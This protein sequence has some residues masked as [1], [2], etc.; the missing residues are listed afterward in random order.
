[1]RYFATIKSMKIGF[2]LSQSAF[3]GGVSSYTKNLA[4]G[5]SR[6]EDLEMIYFYSSLR[7]NYAG[8]LKNVK[9][10]KIPP[11]I[12]EP[13]FNRLRLLPIEIFIGKVDVFH[14][15]DWTQPPTKAFKVT[16]YHDVVP[17][18]YP[19]WSTKK[20][21]DVHKRRL[22]IVEKEIDLVI[23][24]SQ[25]TKKDLLEVSSI[26]ENKIKV[27]YEGVGSQFKQ[28]SEVKKKEFKRRLRLPDEFILAIGGI[29]ERRNLERIKKASKDQ[30]LVITGETIP[31]LSDDEM[32]L[33]YSSA[34]ILLYSSLYEGFGLPILEAF[35]CG[36]PVVTSNRSAML[37]IAGNAAILVNPE[38]IYNIKD[39]ID[40]AFDEKENLIKKGLARVKNFSLE[41]SIEETVKVYRSIL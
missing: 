40:K 35:S 26:P 2:D 27:I 18:K 31:S 25:S 8:P 39:G 34:S 13:L 33:L 11:N 37:E 14:S 17:L 30:N 29:G 6:R 7:R 19:E 41:K 5:L 1:M 23:A 21:V 28:L 22:K 24:V 36:C 32:P 16:T 10:I 9:S 4:F 3:L 20:I 12:L 38:D 15:S